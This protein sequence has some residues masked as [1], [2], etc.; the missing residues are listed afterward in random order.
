MAADGEFLRW[1]D[2]V[3]PTYRVPHRAEVAV[4]AVVALLV[5][6]TDLRQAIG[7][8][9]FCVL[10]YY[11]IANASAWTLAPEHRLWPRSL[12]AVGLVGCATLA[13]TLPGDSVMAGAAV[14][15][16]GALI[17]V[18]RGSTVGPRTL[19]RMSDPG[20]HGG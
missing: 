7:F 4:G 3:H 1:F 19:R 12:A 15:T 2:A 16:V 8:S 13:C 18:M 11:A 10:A 9:S 14:L 17:R 5:A 20:A 6:F